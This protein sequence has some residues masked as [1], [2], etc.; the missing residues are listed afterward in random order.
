MR[1]RIRN[2]AGTRTKNNMTHAQ[3]KKQLQTLSRERGPG[4]PL[5]SAGVPG[6]PVADSLAAGA[7]R[8]GGEQVAAPH[9]RTTHARKAYHDKYTLREKHYQ[10]RR[11]VEKGYARNRCKNL[12]RDGDRPPCGQKTHCNAAAAAAAAGGG[13]GSGSEGHTPAPAAPQPRRGLGAAKRFRRADR[14]RGTLRVP[15]TSPPFALGLRATADWDRSLW[16]VL[17]VAL[18]RRLGYRRGGMQ[19]PQRAGSA[20]RHEAGAAAAA[21]GRR[22][23]STLA[24]R[25][26]KSKRSVKCF[27]TRAVPCTRRHSS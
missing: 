4:T 7:A 10:T 20:G 1:R 2:H 23:L 12:S 19:T 16:S 26:R 11:G 5:A 27:H 15:P 3:S 17:P 22:T 18:R 8:G 14:R 21:A 25:G 24:A 6:R 9:K 13:G